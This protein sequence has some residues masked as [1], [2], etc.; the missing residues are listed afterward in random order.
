MSTPTENTSKKELV[1]IVR[2]S[3]LKVTQ[4]DTKKPDACRAAIYNHILYSLGCKAKNVQSKE[5]AQSGKVYWY[6]TSDAITEELSHSWEVCKVRKEVNELVKHGFIGSMKNPIWGADRTKHFVFGKEQCALLLNRCKELGI[7]L[8]HLELPVDI[9]HLINL[10]NAND[11]NI[12]C[13]CTKHQMQMIHVSNQTDK[14]IEAITESTSEVT[15]ETNPER[16]ESTHASTPDNAQTFVALSSN[17]PLASFLPQIEPSSEREKFAAWQARPS[18]TFDDLVKGQKTHTDHLGT[19]STG[20]SPVE[21]SEHTDQTIARNPDGETHTNEVP[22][23][24]PTVQPLQQSEQEDVKPAKPKRTQEPKITQVQIDR[25]FE[26]MNEVLRSPSVYGQ[27]DFSLVPSRKA[28]DEVKQL[29]KAKALPSVLKAV[30]L[31][32]WNEY[33]NGEYWWRVK[34]RM[35]VPAICGQYSSRAP[36][37]MPKV[38]LVEPPTDTPKAETVVDI[39]RYETPLMLRMRERK[40]KFEASQLQQ[41]KG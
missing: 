25:V 32:M 39:S 27:P 5:A 13:T 38:K 3:F 1:V 15:T 19:Q 6:A 7:C 18:V 21:P 14:S 37:L 29:I 22:I 41:V 23:A 35:T 10:S 40:A 31:D 16:E 20:Y 4:Q 12:G 33:K 28:T 24:P 34:G 17:T 36:G 30:I 11:I 2:P 8:F 26:T 9:I